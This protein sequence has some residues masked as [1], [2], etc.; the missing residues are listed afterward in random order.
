MKILMLLI[1]LTSTLFSQKLWEIELDKNII[2]V[3]LMPDGEHF[4]VNYGITGEN[5]KDMKVEVR[6][7]I[8]GSIEKQILTDEFRNAY[9]ES[10]TEIYFTQD[11]KYFMLKYSNILFDVETLKPVRTFEAILDWNGESIDIGKVQFSKDNKYVFILNRGDF[12]GEPVA[13]YFTT[14][15]SSVYIFDFQTGE[16]IKKIFLPYLTENIEI[17]DDGKYLQ[18]FE[19][20]KYYNPNSGLPIPIH[21][22]DT[23]NLDVILKMPYLKEGKFCNFINTKDVAYIFNNNSNYKFYDLLDSNII[24]EYNFAKDVGSNYGRLISSKKGDKLF[25]FNHKDVHI[26][27]YP[28]LNLLDHKPNSEIFTGIIKLTN[29]EKYTINLETPDRKVI[30]CF[31]LQTLNI[32]HNITNNYFQKENNTITF[33]SQEFIGQIANIGIYN[34]SGSKIGTLHNGIINQE[35]YNFQIPELP[36]GAYYLQCQLPNQNLNFNFMVVR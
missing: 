35:N 5:K 12:D 17:S 3:E 33:N 19:G 16:F 13:P 2:Q 10:N 14:A 24:I 6:K 34:S 27:D 22:I 7:L 23:E 36:S 15:R 31:D 8:D 25:N 1:L 30:K 11:F 9:I 18:T 4:I 32:E 28:E 21:I 29:D 20:L 26:Y